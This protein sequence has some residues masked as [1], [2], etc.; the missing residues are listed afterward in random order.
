MYTWTQQ[1]TK[2]KNIKFISRQIH[3]HL[4]SRH[5]HNIAEPMMLALK[6]AK[7]MLFLFDILL[8]QEHR[9]GKQ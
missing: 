5:I 7:P 9:V 3:M 2:S 8:S 6:V 1:I 4:G